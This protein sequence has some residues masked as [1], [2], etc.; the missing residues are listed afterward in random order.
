LLP[1][2]VVLLYS[3]YI[4]YV[5]HHVECFACIVLEEVV[6]FIRLAITGTQ[7]NVRNK[8]G[9]ICFLHIDIYMT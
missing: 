7:M 5:T 9:S 1:T 2:P 3:P 4:K 8:D 6:E